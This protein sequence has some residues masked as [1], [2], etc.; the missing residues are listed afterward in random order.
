MWNRIYLDMDG[1]LTNFE[2][3]IF[4]AHNKEL[5]LLNWPKGESEITNIWGITIEEFREPMEDENFWINL[6]PDPQFDNLFKLL[7]SYI[8]RG[9]L[10]IATSHSG[11]P[12]AASGKVK[13]LDKYCP[14]IPYAITKH[15]YLFV[16]NNSIL[17]DDYDVNIEKFIKYGGRGILTPKP[18]NSK[19]KEYYDSTPDSVE[20]IKR[21]I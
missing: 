10:C 19:Y 15:K 5:D 12:G 18:W 6:E 1:V 9:E 4:K 21:Y 16:N 3:G 7:D 13:W 20:Y 14:N 11:L 17:I 2:K 8:K